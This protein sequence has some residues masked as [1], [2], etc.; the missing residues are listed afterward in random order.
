MSQVVKRPVLF[1]VRHDLIAHWAVRLRTGKLEGKMRPLSSYLHHV[2]HDTS[3]EIWLQIKPQGHDGTLNIKGWSIRTLPSAAVLYQKFNFHENLPLDKVVRLL[4]PQFLP[5]YCA[6]CVMH[7]RVRLPAVP[8]CLE[9]TYSQSSYRSI[10]LL[11]Q[12]RQL[13]V[14]GVSLN[15]PIEQMKI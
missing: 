10:F 9:S 11:L 1:L 2:S 4:I 14:A 5:H 7:M 3:S 12:K 8:R 6:S 15:D 13:L